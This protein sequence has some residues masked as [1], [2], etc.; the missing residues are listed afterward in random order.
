MKI[1]IKFDISSRVW[2]VYCGDGPTEHC[3]YCDAETK[4]R[5]WVVVTDFVRFVGLGVAGDILYV[6]R[7]HAFSEDHVF[8]NEKAAEAEARRRNG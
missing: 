5:E 7:G 6:L 2:G 1:E 4:T 3:A 8:D